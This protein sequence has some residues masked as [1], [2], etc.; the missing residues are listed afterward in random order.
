MATM[1]HELRTPLNVILGYTG[2]VLEGAMGEIDAEPAAALRRVNES[3]LQLLD[4]I[5]ATLDVTR[6]ESGVVPLDFAPVDL[7]EVLADIEAR[8][9]EVRARKELAFSCDAADGF[10][11]I[12]TDAAK[13]RIVLTNLV[14]NALKFTHQGAVHVAA[15]ADGEWIEISVADSGIGIEKDACEVI[16]EPF[17][18]A[19]AMVGAR[20][21]GVGLGLYIVKRLVDALGGD[22]RLES[23]VG[24]G[25]TFFV[26]LPRDA[27]RRAPVPSAA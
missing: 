9:R 12:V 22:V 27:R 20:F 25:T 23:E 19:D 5:N 21:G 6:L 3:A 26:R 24:R 1:S 4:L 17:R 15:R 7:G 16:F 8:T 13:L 14:G 18:Q 2:L 11:A 10:P